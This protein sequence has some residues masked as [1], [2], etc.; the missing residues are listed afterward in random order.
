MVK[1]SV[2]LLMV[3]AGA[4]HL[5]CEA[6][7]PGAKQGDEPRPGLVAEYFDT[8][9]ALGGLKLRAI[10][11]AWRFLRRVEPK[12]A[13]DSTDA[14]FADSKIADHLLIKWSGLLRVPSEDDWT[15]YL[16]SDDGSRLTLD[17]TLLVDNDG[18]H[19]MVEKSATTKLTAG[20]HVIL[21]EYYDQ[22]GAGGINF[23][24]SSAS[25]PR[26]LVPA[27]VL[28]HKRDELD[29]PAAAED[30]KLRWKLD[31]GQCARYRTYTPNAK[32]DL[33][34][35]DGYWQSV[36]FEY[37][38][39]DKRVYHPNLQIVRE[40]PLILGLTTPERPLHTGRPVDL[41]MILDRGYDYEP[42]RAKGRIERIKPAAPGVVTYALTAKII[43]LKGKIE[44]RQSRIK[45][46]S[47]IGE[48]DFDPDRGAVTRLKF[49][50]TIT[51]EGGKP[52]QWIRELRLADVIKRR[53]ATFESEV[54][55]AIDLGIERLWGW[56]NEKESHWPIWF[57]QKEGPSALALLTILKGSLDRKDPR[58]DKALEWVVE[59]PFTWTYCVAISMMT[60]ESYYSPNDPTKRFKPGDAADKDIASKISPAHKKWMEEAAKWMVSNQ[61]D[62]YWS[63]PSGT[64][65][66]SN[67][68]YAILGF[69]AAQR[70]G[71][72]VDDQALVNTINRLLQ[73]EER[74]GPAVKLVIIDETTPGK[75]ESEVN[76][77]ALG[78][79]YR[80]NP[81][82]DGG[83]RA[84]MTLGAIGTLTILDHMLTK[85]NSG[86]YKGD[87]RAK[88]QAAIRNGW[89]W[90]ATNW[91]VK[92]N[93]NCG[94]GWHLYSLYALERA[95]MLGG[96]GTLNGHDW[97]WEG[98]TWLMANQTADGAWSP[99]SYQGGSVNLHETCFAVLFLKRA[100]IR[101]A[102]GE[103]K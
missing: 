12:I 3:L 16:V 63:Y 54:N 87:L 90:I 22:G 6:P 36:L 93:W 4:P 23:L 88:T 59:Q 94:T 14:P 7:P 13:Y 76:A 65:D 31:A 19:G 33:L 72:V 67:T 102:T 97:Y 71:V 91:S 98:A 48:A 60:V 11:Q 49:D 86:R 69:L 30:L 40:I 32:G 39:D 58:I 66:Y 89:A 80:E 99:Y 56:F 1:N 20:D 64:Q 78:W 74:K 53:H 61:R 47:F 43:G 41:D 103:K 24:W 28:F 29:R 85:M 9:R 10:D 57:D 81:D 5:P 77:V 83:A 38:L 26:E 2:L 50:F 100:T 51:Y 27:D 95:G 46:G 8:H 96:V 37:E 45:E 84:S 82:G 101:V 68:Q 62:N 34:D 15:F 79:A 25:R 55:R 42:A 17:G 18:P 73:S 21:V 70:C 35:W 44:A 52:T 92:M 75:T